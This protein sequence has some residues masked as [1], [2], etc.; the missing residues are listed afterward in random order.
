MVSCETS[1][2]T[3][4]LYVPGGDECGDSDHMDIESEGPDGASED[5]D[6]VGTSV[7]QGAIYADTVP[8]SVGK[9]RQAQVWVYE[10]SFR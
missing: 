1:I 5:L 2:L 9:A 3:V 6:R 7:K 10:L 4:T 8:E